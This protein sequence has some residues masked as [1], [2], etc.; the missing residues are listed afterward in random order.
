MSARPSLSALAADYLSA[1]EAR[2]YAPGTVASRRRHLAELT[3]WLEDRGITH[4]PQV[5]LSV[6]ERYRLHLFGR[7]QPDGRPLGW[8]AQ[9]HRLTAI[10][11]LFRWLTRQHHL[12]HNPVA[13]LE[14]PRRRRRIPRA[15]LTADEMERVLALPDV[16]R[17]LGLRDR[18]LLEV[19]YAT[20]IRR[21]ECAGLKLTDLDFTRRTLFVHQ[22][23]GGRDRYVP[24][25]ERAA[26]W[27]ERYLRTA[28]A[29]YMRPPDPGHVFLSVRGR[30]LGPKRLGACVSEYIERAALGKHGSCHMIRHSMATL[31]L[32]GGADIRHIQA[33]LGHA[34]LGT[35]ALYTHLS[36]QL[37]QDVHARTHPARVSARSDLRPTARLRPGGSGAGPDPCPLARAPDG[38]SDGG[39]LP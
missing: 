37:L 16:S 3:G 36:I 23:K 14:L 21:A 18:T 38:S 30:P 13:D 22:G 9:A 33:I 15:V 10:K 8:G 24:L 11:G 5:T 28:R 35:T 2:G 20:G 1:L 7:R 19:L 39:E 34:E 6:V 29:H 27:L 12:P 31:M 25:G 4:A 17:P 32:E 26:H